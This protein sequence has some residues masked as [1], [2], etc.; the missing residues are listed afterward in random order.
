M[1]NRGVR[2]YAVAMLMLMFAVVLFACCGMPTEGEYSIS[3]DFSVGDGTGICMIGSALS[4][5]PHLRHDRI[6]HKRA[7][8]CSIGAGE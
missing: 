6:A 1:A 2:R 8:D 4:V 5:L 7:Q 3:F